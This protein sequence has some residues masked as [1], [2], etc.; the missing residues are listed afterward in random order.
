MAGPAR[1]FLHAMRA[2]PADIASSGAVAQSYPG[3]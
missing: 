2:L 1:N 3:E